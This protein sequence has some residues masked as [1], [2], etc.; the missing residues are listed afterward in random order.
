M[1]DPSSGI[2][3]M[4]AALFLGTLALLAA[5]IL[6]AVRAI[7]PRQGPLAAGSGLADEAGREARAPQPLVAAEEEDPAA[8]TA[9]VKPPAPTVEAT[10]E[11]FTARIRVRVL[12]ESTRR[13]R[14][15]GMVRV[16][17]FGLNRGR[18][19]ILGE[20]PVDADGRFELEV[21]RGVRLRLLAWARG[22]QRSRDT[23]RIDAI[24]SGRQREVE[25]F[26]DPPPRLCGI[27]VSATTG[28]PVPG[29]LLSAPDPLSMLLQS[30]GRPS[31][32]PIQDQR[33]GDDGTFELWRDGRLSGEYQVLADGYTPVAFDWEAGHDSPSR[34]LV[35]RLQP[36]AGL[37]IRVYDPT[38][39]PVPGAT[40]TAYL[41]SAPV[42]TGRSVVETTDDNGE[43][44]LADLDGQAAYGLAIEHRSRT[45]HWPEAIRVAP[46]E[47][48]GLDWTWIPGTRVSGRL[49]D[50]NG[51]PVCCVTLWL[52]P[53]ESGGSAGPSLRYGSALA[54]PRL[55][56]AA[57][58]DAQG[59][60]ELPSVRPGDWWIGPEAR[61]AAG[62]VE[63]EPDWICP[64]ATAFEVSPGETEREV[65]LVTWRALYATGKV[66][67]SVGEDAV[68]AAITARSECCGGEL[69]CRST[70]DGTFTLGP[71]APGPHRIRAEAGEGSISEWITAEPGARELILQ[72]RE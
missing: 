9:R 71:M 68:G 42:F 31:R 72:L 1:P 10:P 50:Q 16:R 57:Q 63:P 52:W 3:A 46:G 62:A 4:K 32:T 61:D 18:S 2:L 23:V 54:H 8:E 34:P 13:V 56:G 12:E 26:L 41:A 33:V 49:R 58:T 21:P 20:G 25:L 15:D 70:E 44:E 30:R 40:I 69:A 19:A 43:V 6:I 22:D 45:E 11:Q 38:G 14:A 5:G 17:G 66:L 55:V 37:S 53:R 27:V 48:R 35:V 51:E 29:A 64:V 67:T 36:H 39:A 65:E 28:M 7:E 59:R 60:F 24:P 47:H